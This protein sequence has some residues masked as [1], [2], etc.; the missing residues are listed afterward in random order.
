MT[1]EEQLKPGNYVSWRTV[2]YDENYFCGRNWNKEWDNTIY[3]WSHWIEVNSTDVLK[4]AVYAGNQESRAVELRFKEVG[5][6]V[7]E[8]KEDT[9]TKRN[10]DELFN[11]LQAAWVV[12]QPIVESVL[13]KI[14]ETYGV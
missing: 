5:E 3:P 4:L 10:S 2:P 13:S 9:S 11:Y 8:S 6:P 1:E 12:G 7:Q 14:K